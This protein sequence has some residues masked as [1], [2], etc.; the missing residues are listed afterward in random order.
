MNRREN[1]RTYAD[2]HEHLAKLEAAGL[3][4]RIDAPVNKDTEM[5]PLVR[6][7][8]RGGIEEKD[9][10]AFLFTNVVDS[11]GRRYDI[12]VA[13]GVFAAN[14]EIYRIGMNVERLEDIGPKWEAAIANPIPPRI[15]ET[16][17]VHDIVLTGEALKGEGRGLTALP[18]PISTPGFDAAPFLTATAVITRDPE[19]QVQ[20]LGTY[21]CHL[22]GAT[23]MGVMILANLNSG[24][25]DHWQK[26]RAKGQRMPIAACM[27]SVPLSARQI[28]VLG[29][30]C[31]NCRKTKRRRLVRGSC[32]T[33][34]LMPLM[35]RR[36]RKWARYIGS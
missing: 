15:V 31:S 25:H 18:V 36:S 23:R 13:I 17:P 12:P 24:G 20:N 7:Q 9:R 33:T 5:H 10:K 30:P 1:P 21:R 32:I 8:V 29:A 4:Y 26:H 22:K 2:L 34:R 35:A 3:V 27:V 19:T 14:S 28:S 11:K 6:W 16:G